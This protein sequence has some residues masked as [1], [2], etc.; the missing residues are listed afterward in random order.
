MATTL[1]D[2]L[3]MLKDL[4]QRLAWAVK[5]PNA[6]QSYAALGTSTGQVGTAKW[7]TTENTIAS[8]G[9][10]VPGLT[11]LANTSR[12]LRNVIDSLA[13]L[14]RVFNPPAQTPQVP[15]GQITIAPGSPPARQPGFP[16]PLAGATPSWPTTT[17]AIPPL[18]AQMSVANPTVTPPPTMPSAAT[19]T[20]F[21]WPSGFQQRVPGRAPR[22]GWAPK[23]T[24][25]TVIEPRWPN[26]GS[27]TP[28]LPPFK[29]PVASTQPQGSGSA[30]TPISSA[31]DSQML[32]AL[33][34]LKDAVETLTDQLKQP[35]EKKAGHQPSGGFIP[36][37][38]QPL[39]TRSVAPASAPPGQGFA[40]GQ[41]G[42]WQRLL[43]AILR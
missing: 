22:A 11:D 31:S 23:P 37:G 32:Q 13:L 17:P 10:F 3:L 38:P 12:D 27:P 25:K 40:R 4:P 14:R 35:E 1:T 6:V 26:I 21:V 7:P 5:Q 19:S 41:V 29:Y 33:R 28:L 43:G 18:P 39:G 36:G 24:K 16:T 42:P 2:V 8:L 15:S 9:R 20:P 30:Q 34:D